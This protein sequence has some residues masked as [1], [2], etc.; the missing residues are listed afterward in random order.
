MYRRLNNE[1]IGNILIFL[2]SNI[3]YLSMTKA[4][5][6][7]YII[8]EESVKRTGSPVTWLDY[9]VWEMGPV[10]V[11]IYNEIKFNENPTLNKYVD[12][13]RTYNP[14]RDQIEIFIKDKSEFNKGVFNRFEINLLG[15]VTERFRNKT[16]ED[17]IKY[18]HE[19]DSLWHRIVL[20]ENLE[21]RFKVC[22]TS[23]Y[24]IEFFELIKDNP[25]LQ[26]SAISAS[27]AME[28]HESL[29]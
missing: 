15:S 8:D 26:L 13:Q 2:A 12:F 14:G 4:L 23:N 25:V 9:K 27:E 19:E 18:L 6:L 20:K 7:L 29:S 16:A 5:K 21:S 17:L 10:A 3:P 11:D 22:A 1:K 24:S 28:F